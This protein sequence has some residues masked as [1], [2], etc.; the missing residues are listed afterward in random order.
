MKTLVDIVNFE[1]SDVI[2]QVLIDVEEY[3]E[4]NTSNGPVLAGDWVSPDQLE[5]WGID[6]D[7]AIY[8]DC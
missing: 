6:A 5:R 2:A 7:A 3:T 1:T 8:I 4:T